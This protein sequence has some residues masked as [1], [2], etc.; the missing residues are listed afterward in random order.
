LE[1]TPKGAAGSAIRDR[2]QH[3][4]DFVFNGQDEIEQQIAALRVTWVNDNAARSRVI[5]EFAA[6]QADSQYFVTPVTGPS[7][8][9]DTSLADLFAGSSLLNS[10]LTAGG[11]GGRPAIAGSRGRG[12]STL[13]KRLGQG[14]KFLFTGRGHTLLN[15]LLWSLLGLPVFLATRRRYLLRLIGEV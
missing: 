13:L 9:G 3:Q 14:L 5:A 2:W 12:G 8:N 15:I 11:S 1:A 7:A 6:T 4:Q 10:D